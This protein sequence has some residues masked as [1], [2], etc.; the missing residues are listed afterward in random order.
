MTSI[1][2][3]LGLHLWLLPQVEGAN[4]RIA[5]GTLLLADY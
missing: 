3:I 4:G 5:M 2:T 1:S